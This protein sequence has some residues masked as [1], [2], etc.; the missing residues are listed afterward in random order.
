MNV[1]QHI[2]KSNITLFGSSYDELQKVLLI[3]QAERAKL[4]SP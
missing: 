2:G 3:S 4:I 1:Q